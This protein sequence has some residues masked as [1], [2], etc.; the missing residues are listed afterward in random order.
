[1]EGVNS[2]ID[3][4]HSPQPMFW[5]I[6]FLLHQ[7]HKN[8]HLFLFVHYCSR[9]K[10]SWGEVLPSKLCYIQTH[11]LNSSFEPTCSQSMLSQRQNKCIDD[12]FRI[13]FFFAC[14]RKLNLS[15]W[16]TRDNPICYCCLP[17]N[18]GFHKFFTFF[19]N[20]T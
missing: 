16:L 11:A 13:V 20:N 8:T 5:L 1:M 2:N 18:F 12:F 15:G 19:S 7:H 6:P 4:E 14:I 3:S 17:A 10:Y 9:W